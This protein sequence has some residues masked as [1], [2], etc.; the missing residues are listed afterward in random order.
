MSNGSGVYSFTGLADGP[1]HVREQV[2]AP[3]FVRTSAASIDLTI[4]GG[5]TFSGQNIGNFPVVY[6][7]GSTG[8]TFQVS[9]DGTGT[10]IQIIL[11]GTTTFTVDKTLPP[12]LTFSTND[13]SDLLAIDY[14]NGSPVPAGGITYNASINTIAKL[15]RV[16]GCAP[17]D[18]LEIATPKKKAR[19]RGSK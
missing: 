4:A 6:A 9:L 15:C 8:D 18:L 19:A 7:G 17:G 1:Y 5:N 16:L 2:P 10:K 13:G 3:N 14:S 12:S 11:N